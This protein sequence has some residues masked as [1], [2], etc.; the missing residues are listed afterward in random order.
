MAVKFTRDNF[1]D[2]LAAYRARIEQRRKAINSRPPKKQGG[3]R[4]ISEASKEFWESML[5]IRASISESKAL[6]ATV[7]HDLAA[8]NAG[9]IAR[10]LTI[11]G[12]L[13][14]T[15]NADRLW[16]EEI[17]PTAFTGWLAAVR[18]DA[19]GRYQKNIDARLW[20]DRFLKSRD[21][22]EAFAYMR[23]FEDTLDFR[24]G[25][26][27]QDIV[28]AERD[29]LPIAWLRHIDATGENRSGS[30]KQREED[31][32]KVLFST[33]TVNGIAPWL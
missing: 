5:G 27:A 29:K 22:D 23:L 26:W 4:A 13:D 18:D 33:R 2:Y 9:E 10:G 20:F 15:D 25:L 19:R 28:N 31:R 17:E 6:I 8:S 1:A 30:R 21:A 14:A 16:R 24:Q 12:M 7:R 3:L 32:K 11:A